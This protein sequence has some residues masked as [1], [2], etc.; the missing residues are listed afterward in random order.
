MILIIIFQHR[1]NIGRL[2]KGNE[3]KF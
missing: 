3:N 2:L 1:S